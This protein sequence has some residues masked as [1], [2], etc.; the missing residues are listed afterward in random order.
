MGELNITQGMIRLKESGAIFDFAWLVVCWL[1][2]YELNTLFLIRVVVRFVSVVKFPRLDISR[3]DLSEDS[4]GSSSNSH[5][6]VH[7]SDPLE[8][9][10]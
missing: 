5:S 9:L 10:Q 7:S 2:I 6:R 3:G 8:V 4:L 1:G